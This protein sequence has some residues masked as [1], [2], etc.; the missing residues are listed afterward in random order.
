M[1]N[2]NTFFMTIF[3]ALS[4]SC[5]QKSQEVAI[6]ATSPEIAI[7]NLDSQID[8]LSKLIS[9]RADDIHKIKYV[10][11]MLTKIQFFNNFDDL[12]KVHQLVD[13][14]S[15]QKYQVEINLKFLLFVHEYDKAL[16]EVEKLN[17][18]K[19]LYDEYMLKIQLA[20]GL[21]KDKKSVTNSKSHFANQIRLAI[22]SADQ[23][24]FKDAQ[25]ELLIALQSYQDVSPFPIAY[26]YFNLGVLWGEKGDDLKKAQ[27]F[28]KNAISYI[29]TYSSAVV[30]L[31]EIYIN[32]RQYDSAL[33]ILE[34]IETNGDPE[35]LATLAEIYT[36]TGKVEQSSF[37]SDKAAQRYQE[38]LNLYPL[39]FYDHATEFYLGVGNNP[40]LAKSYALS[41]LRN[42]KGQRSFF[43]VLEAAK[44]T[45]DID[46]QCQTIAKI[47][48][49]AITFEEYKE[50][51]QDYLKP[52]S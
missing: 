13:L 24:R 21:V 50:S 18:Q 27:D 4:F 33:K 28:Y 3:L 8:T 39:A 51:Y 12:K 15:H 26:I 22:L 19:E 47:P 52:C 2:M 5:N 43:L 36:K 17:K 46:L 41:N 30:H 48:K 7:S 6:K 10:D 11:L 9:S 37:Y 40:E 14:N 23:G 29:P 16:V 25:K 49:D 44:K 34:P 42:R 45:K 35:V 20:K 31:S 38:L 1:K 32:K